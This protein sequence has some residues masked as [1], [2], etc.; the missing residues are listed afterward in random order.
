M[1]RYGLRDEQSARSEQ[2]LAGSPGEVG[3]N[4]ERGQG[5]E[6]AAAIWK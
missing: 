2:L 3:R 4:S 6:V 5:Q 1:K